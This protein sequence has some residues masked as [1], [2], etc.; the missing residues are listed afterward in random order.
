[1]SSWYTNFGDL[2]FSLPKHHIT[3]KL[4]VDGDLRRSRPYKGLLYVHGIIWKSDGNVLSG[5]VDLFI[6]SMEETNPIARS[7]GITDDRVMMEQ[8]GFWQKFKRLQSHACDESGTRRKDFDIRRE[9]ELWYGFTR[10][11]DSWFGTSGTLNSWIKPINGKE[12]ADVVKNA[13]I[14]GSCK[15]KADLINLLPED[16]WIKTLPILLLLTTY[17][18][19]PWSFKWASKAA[20]IVNKYE[21]QQ[22]ELRRMRQLVRICSRGSL[23]YVLQ[24]EGLNIGGWGLSAV[25]ALATVLLES[26]GRYGR[27][28][29]HDLQNLSLKHNNLKDD[30]IPALATVI[31][32]CPKLECLNLEHN[33]IGNEGLIVLR[34]SLPYSL[35]CLDLSSN[36]ISD[37]GVIE[38]PRSLSKGLKGLDL[39]G[40][41][42][43][44]EGIKALIQN[45]RSSPQ[46]QGLR[47]RTEA[48][49]EPEEYYLTAMMAKKVRMDVPR[50]RPQSVRLSMLDHEEKVEGN[51]VKYTFRSSQ[52]NR[53]TPDEWESFDSETDYIGILDTKLNVCYVEKTSLFGK[54]P[55]ATLHK[56][57]MIELGRWDEYEDW[58]KEPGKNYHNLTGYA[59]FGHFRGKWSPNSCT[60]NPVHSGKSRDIVVKTIIESGVQKLDQAGKKKDLHIMNPFLWEPLKKLLDKMTK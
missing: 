42:I 40:N 28:R 56:N 22:E 57:L 34:R 54:V 11:Y 32:C 35:K 26:W 51:D 4:I 31:S 58:I 19:E 6:T 20:P 39:R 53:I 59:G 25:K 5:Q 2:T 21:F 36:N 18:G 27:P 45:W 33:Q 30:Q 44:Q 15:S 52:R 47:F 43:Y 55:K 9:R 17:T 41:R 24:L 10:K 13:G 48:K 23:L 3:R 8:L 7:R 29:C 50:S 1:M 12:C 38:L 49:E 37:E 60:L 14:R 16:L 46:L